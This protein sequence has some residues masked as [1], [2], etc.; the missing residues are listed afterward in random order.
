MMEYPAAEIDKIIKN[1]GKRKT[2]VLKKKGEDYCTD[3]LFFILFFYLD[4][5]SLS[6]SI[7]LQLLLNW[8]SNFVVSEQLN[9]V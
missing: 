6:N 3:I 8:F 7:T 5:V 1:M 4:P 2:M 9:Q